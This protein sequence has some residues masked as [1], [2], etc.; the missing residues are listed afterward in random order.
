MLHRTNNA[1][2]APGIIGPLGR[3]HDSAHNEPD[4]LAICVPDF[5]RST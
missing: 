5:S 2:L 4:A 1:A 3:I